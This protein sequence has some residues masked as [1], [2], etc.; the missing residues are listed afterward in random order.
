LSSLSDELALGTVVV[1]FICF[2]RF[3]P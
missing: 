2:P 3:S 1:L